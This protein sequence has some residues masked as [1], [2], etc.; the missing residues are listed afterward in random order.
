MLPAAASTLR[1]LDVNL[2]PVQTHWDNA[3]ETSFRDSGTV[4]MVNTAVV[5]ISAW[6]DDDEDRIRSR[7][8]F[9]SGTERVERVCSSIDDTVAALGD[10]LNR[11][12]RSTPRYS[13]THG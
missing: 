12:H 2:Q 13:G 11:W 6:H 9:D 7:I 8:T 4:T 3:V 1:H 5:L 10:L